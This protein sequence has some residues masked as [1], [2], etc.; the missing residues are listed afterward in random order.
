M[1]LKRV[2]SIGLTAVCAALGVTVVDGSPASATTAYG[3]VWPRVCFY[4]GEP[5]WAT[6]SPT[7]AYQDITSYWQY[8][9]TKSV[10]SWIAYNSRNDD[11][12][13]LGF[14]SGYTWCLR[15]NTAKYLPDLR[16][17]YVNKIRIM[18][19]PYCSY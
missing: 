17:G 11:G 3:C 2:L 8:L 16:L 1:K 19:S 12:A 14:T 5:E 18:N 7:S 6:Q 13:L 15:P 4:A 10:G 9:G